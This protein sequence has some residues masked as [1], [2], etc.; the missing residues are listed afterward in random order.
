MVAYLMA[1]VVDVRLTFLFALVLCTGY[2]SSEEFPDLPTADH[3]IACHS[4]MVDDEGRVVSIG[5]DWR[6]TM[7]AHSARDPY[8]QAS[9]RRETID[10]PAL[11]AEIEDTCATCHMPAARAKAQ[12][13][14]ELGRVFDHLAVDAPSADVA[15]DGVNCVVCHG[16]AHDGL[17][18]RES[19]DG[20]FRIDPGVDGSPRAFGPYEIE[21]GLSRVMHSASGVV[22]TQSMHVQ[23][24]ELCA[25]CHT[26]FTRPD[27]EHGITEPFPEQVPYLEWQQSVYSPDK[28][29]Q[30]CHM[31]VVPPSPIASVLGEAREGLSTHQFRGGNAFMLRLLTLYRDELGVTAPT[32]DLKRAADATQEHLQTQTAELAVSRIHQNS[33][34]LEFDVSISNL[35]GHKLP[36]AYPSR[37]VW[38]HVEVSDANG[39]SFFESGALSPDGSIVGNDNDLDD[40][41]YEPHYKEITASDQV[42]IYEPIIV[43]AEG[44]VT[45]GLLRAVRYVKDNRILPKGFDKATAAPETAVRGRAIA[46]NDFSNGGDT[47]RYVVPLKPDIDAATI[48]VRLMFQ[49]IGFR[50]AENLSPYESLE[51]VRFTRYYREN[52]DTSAIPLASVE[53]TWRSQ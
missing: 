4:N 18:E 43:D 19:F 6:A 41:R 48:S 26:L 47:I 16:I 53:V 52:A 15:M 12:V 32:E 31:P 49:T 11:S 20:G 42:Q 46:D 14:G 40:S 24:S 1:G 25:T 34:Y 33:E 51:T 39:A 7:M 21:A 50:W 22:P 8:W 35:A 23:S 10:H 44:R 5:H 29:C 17:G 27:D 37:R 3:C 13:A 45:T 28:S 38:L 30:S 36:T 9:V 2:L